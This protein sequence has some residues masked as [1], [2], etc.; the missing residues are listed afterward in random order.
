MKPE[1]K[2]YRDKEGNVYAVEQ[3]IKNKRWV[4]VRVN[5]GGNRKGCKQFCASGNQSIVQ[6]LLDKASATNGW[7]EVSL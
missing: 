7:E 5:V 4:V 6:S 3:S 2:K 1:M